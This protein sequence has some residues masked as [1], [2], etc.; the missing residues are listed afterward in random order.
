[1]DLLR[2]TSN[3]ADDAKEASR[4][5]KRGHD[6]RTA[7]DEEAEDEA[8]LEHNITFVDQMVERLA[9]GDRPLYNVVDVQL[10]HIYAI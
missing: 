1:V 5:R 2:G 9:S 7:S 4:E 10:Q 8:V 6:G 3:E